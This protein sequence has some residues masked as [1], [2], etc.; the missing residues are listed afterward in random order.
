VAGL[1]PFCLPGSQLSVF[2]GKL[3]VGWQHSIAATSAR[4]AKPYF[5]VR[6]QLLAAPLHFFFSEAYCILK[7]RCR[8]LI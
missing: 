1:S 7:Q 6:V 8:A 4:S 3:F 2:E 5:R